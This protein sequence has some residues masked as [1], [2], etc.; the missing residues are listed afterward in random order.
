M[1]ESEESSQQ[2]VQKA[3]NWIAENP[4]YTIQLGNYHVY[5]EEK[6]NCHIPKST[7]YQLLVLYDEK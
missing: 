6:Y 7:I 1:F 2:V 3:N 4:T 5:Q